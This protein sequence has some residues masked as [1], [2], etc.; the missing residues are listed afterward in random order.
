[1]AMSDPVGLATLDA[2]ERHRAV[3]RGFGE[4]VAATRHWQAATPVPAWVAVDVVRHLVE[5]FPAFL[6]SGGV[7]LPGGPAVDADPVGAWQAQADAVQGLLDDRSQAESSFTHPYA[8]THRLGDAIDRFYT[9]DVFMHTW[10]LA[11]AA[12]VDIQLD[13][14]YCALLVEGMEAIDELLRSSGQYGPRFTV[15]DDA[16]AMTRLI[17]F[18]GRDPNWQA[19]R[20]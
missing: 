17:G 12:G 7:E 19:P 15:A 9:A 16:E 5:W 1:M 14:S 8:G 6:A 10:D 3:A 18:I 4:V 20:K 11:R 2:A 13:A